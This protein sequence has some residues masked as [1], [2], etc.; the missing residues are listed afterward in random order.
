MPGMIGD[1][2]GQVF[3]ATH[4]ELFVL[5]ASSNDCAVGQYDRFEGNTFTCTALTRCVRGLTFETAPATNTSDRV[6]APVSAA[7]DSIFQYELEAPTLVDD[8]E[9]AGITSCNPEFEF[10]VVPPT[11]TTDR[12]CA[13]RSFCV[14]PHQYEAVAGTLT[15]DR[16]CVAVSDCEDG[17]YESSAPTLIADRACGTCDAG[18]QVVAADG[19]GCDAAAGCSE[20]RFASVMAYGASDTVC[21]VQS[22][23]ASGQFAAAAATSSSDTVC[24]VCDR[25]LTTVGSDGCVDRCTACIDGEAVQAACTMTSTSFCIFPPRMWYAPCDM[26][27]MSVACLS[28]RT[29]TIVV[30]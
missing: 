19:Q 21:T 28:Q 25:D 20:G 22:T 15:T 14:P 18:T 7:C 16:V 29:T 5:T 10:E 26:L 12:R 1:V 13:G 3:G 2:S 30:M 8:R 4:V 23:C 11:A 24:V 9:C 27:H 17:A 6:C